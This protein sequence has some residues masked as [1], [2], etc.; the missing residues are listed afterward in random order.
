MGVYAVLV[1]LACAYSALSGYSASDRWEIFLRY[2]DVDTIDF[3]SS[4]RLS[5]PSS[6][7]TVTIPR[8]DFEAK[9]MQVGDLVKIKTD[10]TTEA[11]TIQKIQTTVDTAPISLDRP[12]GNLNLSEAILLAPTY[13]PILNK[14][15]GFY[16][17]RMPFLL[18]ICGSLLGLFFLMTLVTGVIY[19][20]HGA[21][22]SD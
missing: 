8:A 15:I 21:L 16:V 12:V 5:Q 20:F 4:T 1:L 19:F 11:A 7:N 18:F 9:G 6:G 22:F 10:Q 17:F 13:D 2:F 14:P 3:H